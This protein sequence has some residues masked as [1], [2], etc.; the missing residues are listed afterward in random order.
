MSDREYTPAQLSAFAWLPSDGAWADKPGRTFSSAVGSL[1]LYHRN[2]AE[3][4]TGAFGARGG[5]I[6]RYRLTP[7]GQAEKAR[8]IA[9]GKIE[10]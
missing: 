9:E 2:I 10:P 8:L 6:V 5:W 3:S 7:A 1:C 4:I